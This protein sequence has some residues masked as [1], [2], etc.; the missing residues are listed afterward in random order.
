MPP[1]R[2]GSGRGPLSAV[3]RPPFDERRSGYPVRR[4]DEGQPG[5]PRSRRRANGLSSWTARL[6]RLEGAHWLRGGGVH[7]ELS[8]LS[9]P[10]QERRVGAV[11]VERVDTQAINGDARVGMRFGTIISAPDVGPRYVGGPEVR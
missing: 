9:R 3:P 10:T 7:H 5:S 1:V 11:D 8:Q 6:C 4:P 2:Y